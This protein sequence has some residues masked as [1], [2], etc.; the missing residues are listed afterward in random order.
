[1]R[2]MILLASLFV[3]AMLHARQPPSG[4]AYDDAVARRLVQL[5]RATRFEPGAQITSYTAV[6]RERAA[7]MV[8]APLKDRTLFR[9][10][11]AARV[12][13]SRDGET[14]ALLLAS[15]AQYPGGKRVGPGPV[16]Y[17]DPTSDRF[18]FGMM[19][20]DS[21]DDDDPYHPLAEG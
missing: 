12:R 2:G 1:M 19:R 11:Q 20:E 14:V 6:V 5:A 4:G 8:R 15:L 7:V 17:F 3:P 18:S 16:A 9:L 10:E 21:G 13:W